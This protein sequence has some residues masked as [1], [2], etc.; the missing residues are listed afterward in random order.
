MT[1]GLLKK[2]IGGFTPLYIELEDDI[3]N[4]T[5][6]KE[7]YIAVIYVHSLLDEA[8]KVLA[9]RL[10]GQKYP[11]ITERIFDEWITEYFGDST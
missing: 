2:Q 3:I 10:K 7:K 1:G 5:D 8:I 4:N 11:E 6:V 9:E